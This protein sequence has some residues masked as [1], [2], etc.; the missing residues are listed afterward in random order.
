[1]VEFRPEDNKASG[2]DTKQYGILFPD[3]HKISHADEGIA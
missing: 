3:A 1:V 2:S